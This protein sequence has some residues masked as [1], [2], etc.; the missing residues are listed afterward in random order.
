MVF[1]APVRLW[2]F[3]NAVLLAA[4]SLWGL[5]RYPHLPHRLP[6]HI[7]VDGVDAWTDRS[8]GSAFVLVFVFIGA[9]VLL[10]A[11]AELTLRVTPHSELPD[12]TAAPFAPSLARS[13]VNRPRT[14][15]SAL[16]I[17]RALLVLNTCTGISLAIGCAVLW[18]SA[19]ERQVSG[20]LFTAMIVPILVGTAVTLASAVRDR[21]SP[22]S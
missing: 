15:A 12:D 19:P 6:Q 20:W 13:S 3:P 4:L 10:T 1:S 18:R 9:T 8:I 17:A 16:W 11:C 5:A 2:L 7:S 14:R 22:A 21:K